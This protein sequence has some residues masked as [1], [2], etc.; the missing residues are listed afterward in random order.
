MLHVSYGLLLLF[1]GALVDLLYVLAVCDFLFASVWVLLVR[2]KDRLD[3]VIELVTSVAHEKDLKCLFDSDF[4]L[5][6]LV[7]HEEL[8]QIEQL[9]R[10]Q[11]SLVVDATL[12]HSHEFFFGNVA[13]Q[14]VIDLP[15][16]QVDFTTAWLAAQILEHVRQVNGSN[17]V[18]GILW[19]LGVYTAKR[20]YQQCNLI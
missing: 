11:I 20:D 5:V 6:L 4:A 7:V 14:I 15:D 10:L 13:I 16:D 17:L 1:K 3:F 12:V 8:D 2:T 18:L 19:L 9:A